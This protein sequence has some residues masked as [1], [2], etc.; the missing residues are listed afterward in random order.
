[1]VEHL[2]GMAGFMT[3]S[4][5]T[6]KFEGILRE[7]LN[8]T[9]LGLISI[10]RKIPAEYATWK[11]S[12]VRAGVESEVECNG[13]QKYGVPHGIDNDTYL[14]LQEIYIEQGCPENGQ[15]AFSMY[16]LIQM[17]GLTDTGG[18][19]KVLRQSL[20][21]LSATQ[22]WIGGAW[23]SHEDEEWLTAGFRLIERLV[24]T[25]KRADIDGAKSVM[26][27]L[28]KEIVR[29]IRNG[30]FKPVSTALLRELGQ[31]SRA[32]YR[33]IDSLRH[34][35]VEPDTKSRVL[36]IGLMD[37]AQRCGIATDRPDK[38]R[39]TLEPIHD[40]LMKMGYLQSVEMLGR[41]KHQQVHYVFGEITAEADPQLVAM[42]TELNVPLV[43]ARKAALDY[44]EKIQEGIALAKALLQHGYQPH[45]EVGFIIDVVRTFG[46]G[47]YQWP[48]ASEQKLL[49]DSKPRKATPV[50]TL[51]ED[52][53]EE[54]PRTLGAARL[55]LKGTPLPEQV[56]LEAAE[57]F[58]SGDV[59]VSE[60]L[61]L[62]A[63]SE[64]QRTVLGWQVRKHALRG[65]SE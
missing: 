57:L 59:S 45:N 37:L 54:P 28:P 55:L 22:Y 63:D 51:F 42:M 6:K 14:A 7:D 29:N 9:Q 48:Q 52:V 64:G 56:L 39:R 1:M 58:V 47:K 18:N 2:S 12:F 24:F 13:T 30:Y 60:L 5:P 23:R 3:E 21:R 31:P 46:S 8:V 20:E 36:E 34:D 27:T 50:A 10:Q 32:A 40:D 4:K 15:F 17:C 19:R 44:P 65:E 16:Q 35:P 62:K 41:G 49:R 11:V 38:I 61:N 43:A 53:P 25:R 26:V 33:V